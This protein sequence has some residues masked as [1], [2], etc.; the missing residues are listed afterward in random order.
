M[1]ANAY[2][3]PS[4]FQKLLIKDFPLG[5]R[6]YL[7]SIEAGLPSEALLEL[8]QSNPVLLTFR[9][10]GLTNTIA[11]TVN[12]NRKAIELLLFPTSQ[13]LLPVLQSDI[14]AEFELG[15]PYTTETIVRII[16]KVYSL[17]GIQRRPAKEHINHY[18]SV[19]RDFS[20]NTYTLG[21]WGKPVFN[22]SDQDSMFNNLYKKIT[23]DK[24]YK[25]QYEPI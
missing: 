13:H 19:K 25:N 23:S 10:G 11:K 5:L 20:N 9:Q 8:E 16:S 12:Y 21:I 1:L 6:I 7:D 24:R 2:L 15:I 3:N 14:E 4:L 18:F 22:L 17:R